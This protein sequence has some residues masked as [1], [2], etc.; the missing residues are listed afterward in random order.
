MGRAKRAYEAKAQSARDTAARAQ[1]LEHKGRIVALPTEAEG[2]TAR[3]EREHREVLTARRGVLAMGIRDTGATCTAKPYN[4]GDNCRRMM[5]PEEFA[6]D[7]EGGEAAVV[8]EALGDDPRVLVHL[9]GKRGPKCRYAAV[10]NRIPDS[11]V[12][13]SDTTDHVS[14]CHRHPRGYVQGALRDVETPYYIRQRRS[15]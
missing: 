4:H 1:W 13:R 14:R 6:R 11:R 9:C 10:Y 8:R 3:A 12:S 5:T 7:Y 15:A 2:A